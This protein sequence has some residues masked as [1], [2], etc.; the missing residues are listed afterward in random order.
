MLMHAWQPVSHRSTYYIHK[1]HDLALICNRCNVHCSTLIRPR[2]TPQELITLGTTGSYVP[3]YAWQ[4]VHVFGIFMSMNCM[5]QHYFAIDIMAIAQH[6]KTP[7]CCQIRPGVPQ[8]FMC[9]CMHGSR[10]DTFMSKNC[11]M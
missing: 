5:I 7:E 8:E 1:L 10:F 3:T 4:P 11:M 6:N 9:L 2:N